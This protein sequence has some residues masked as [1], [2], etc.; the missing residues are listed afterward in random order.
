MLVI[1]RLDVRLLA[2]HMYHLQPLTINM[3]MYIYH[4]NDIRIKD[5]PAS[6]L[7]GQGLRVR[8]LKLP[9][10]GYIA[11]ARPVFTTHSYDEHTPPSILPSTRL[12]Y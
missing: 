12:C 3:D 11:L 4:I 8:D 6:M 1:L 2:K 10:E 5:H 9:D 7:G